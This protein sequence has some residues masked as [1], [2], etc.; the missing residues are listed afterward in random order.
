MIY[1]SQTSEFLNYE[2]FHYKRDFPTESS[3]RKLTKHKSPGEDEFL[4]DI[5]RSDNII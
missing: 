5:V 2:V 1:D 3:E 4:F